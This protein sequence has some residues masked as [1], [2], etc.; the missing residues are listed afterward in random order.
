MKK[1]E[2]QPVINFFKMLNAFQR[3]YRASYMPGENRK[4]N[5]VEH[6][7]T[8]ALLSWYIIDA[9]GLDLD[10]DKAIKYALVHDIPEVYAGDTQAFSTDAQLLNSQKEREKVARRKLKKDFPE[11]KAIHEEIEK[12]EARQD[13]ESIFV[14]ALDKAH[15]VLIELLQD[16][17]TIKEEKLRY[18]QAVSLKRKTTAASQEISDLLEQLIAILDKDKKL[19]F[20]EFTD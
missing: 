14:H 12:Y 10:K 18:A 11:A 9:F 8:L 3:V 15:P 1:I 13:P 17:R 5:D 6:S 2:A 4:E 7:Y 19:Y 20:G 16:G